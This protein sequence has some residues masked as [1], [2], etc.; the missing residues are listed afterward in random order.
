MAG[1]FTGMVRNH[2]EPPMPKTWL[3]RAPGGVWPRTK[4]FERFYD[5]DNPGDFIY[6]LGSAHSHHLRK[7]LKGAGGEALV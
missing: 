7:P 1:G 5:A 6:K 4:N 3:E 2:N